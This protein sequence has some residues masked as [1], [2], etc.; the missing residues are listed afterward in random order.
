MVT[1][2]PERGRKAS[3][4]RGGAPFRGSAGLLGLAAAAFL[5]AGCASGAPASDGLPY[6]E[7][8]PEL[9]V[10]GFL[11][12][13][14]RD[15][16]RG[17]ARLFGT[18]NGPAERR[19]GRTDVEQRMFVLAAFLKHERFGVRRSGL[20]E[21]PN[22]MRLLADMVGTRNG[23]VTVPFVVASYRDRWFVEQVITDPITGRG[24]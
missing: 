21:G 13:A 1:R 8:T 4:G 7:E 17:M 5:A 9:A 2:A 19:F 14:K 15:D 20:T 18:V 16:Y 6:G 22:R 23:N 24:R 11:E 12:A 3:S 10:Q